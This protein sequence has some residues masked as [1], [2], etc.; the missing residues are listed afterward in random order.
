MVTNTI[1]RLEKK[2]VSTSSFLVLITDLSTRKAFDLANIFMHKNTEI[3]LCDSCNKTDRFLLEKAYGKKIEL[4]RK[5]QHFADDLGRILEKYS[6][7]KIVYFPIEEDT[8]LLVYDF[9][10]QHKYPN[11]FTNLPP[12]KSFDIVRDKGAFSLFCLDNG[13]PVPAEYACEDLLALK[14]LPSGLIIKPRSGSGSVGILFIDTKEEL[15]QACKEL[16]M[17]KY[18]IQ[19]RLENPKDVEGGFFLFY[20]GQ[21][22]SYYG[23]R[24][25]RTYPV[26][27]GVSIY[28]KCDLNPE[29]EAL[30]TELLQKLEWSG[31]AMVEFLYDPAA[32]MYKIIEVN[33]RLWGSL[34]L[35]EFCGSEMFE[36]YCR[37]ALNMPV[38]EGNVEKER[39]LRW[40][41][42]R[43]L[44]V[45]FQQK[46]KIEKFWHFDRADTCYVNFSYSSYS[47]SLL[48][49]FYNMINPR[50]LK[51]LLQKVAG[52]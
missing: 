30:G 51:R 16:D 26:S 45:Y 31:L 18:I 3:V 27:G 41:F 43:E 29:L 12:R 11:F 8:T 37:S 44:L 7:K 34:M 9:L 33:P 36:N 10:Q 17:R 1:S 28:S 25:I 5:E 48:F 15:L 21:K 46:G 42:P 6:H 35:A 38:K 24:R 22:I 19:E 39:Y 20:E 4:L 52:K 40:F 32:Q 2:M 49:T 23:H 13:I 47:R 14:Q 50:K